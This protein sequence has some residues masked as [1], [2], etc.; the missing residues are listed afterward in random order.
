MRSCCRHDAFAC[1]TRGVPT[2]PTATPR[3]L[4]VP[5]AAVV[6]VSLVA[7]GCTSF[8][9]SSEDDDGVA[10]ADRPSATVTISPA[11]LTPFCQAMI[12]LADQLENDPP[13]DFE[14][15]I[16]AT[17]ERIADEVPEAIRGDFDAVLADLRGQ[18]VP[19]TVEDIST[20][21]FDPL[22]TV[23]DETGATLPAG[24]PFF[25]EGYDPDDTP[26]LRFNAYVDFECRDV[27]NNP[28]PPPTQPLS[29]VAATSDE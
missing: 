22:P 3:H 29:D 23:T 16:I 14:A 15:E 10:P 28:G 11:R 4:S 8:G 7:A 9:S 20:T 17:Y 6:L 25:D 5:L 26:A 27:A 19:D 2:A 1:H 24:D 13:D 18:P 21:S 12:D